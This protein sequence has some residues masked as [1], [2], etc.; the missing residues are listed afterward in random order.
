MI[1]TYNRLTYLEEALRS[2]LQQDPG[3]EEMQ[4]AVVDNCS[5]TVDTEAFIRKIAGDRVEF[6]RNP[7]NV[8][9]YLNCD[10][11]ITHARGHWVH[12]LHDDD[13]VLPGFYATLATAIQSHPEVSA[14]FCRHAFIDPQ[15]NRTFTMWLERE[16]A[17]V[18]DPGDWL[19]RLATCNRI[20]FPAIVVKRDAY[21]QAGGFVAESYGIA[22]DWEMWVRLAAAG[23]RFWYEPQI[24]ALYRQ[25]GAA[26]S[27]AH[28]QKGFQTADARR[29]IEVFSNYFPPDRRAQLAALGLD[30]YAFSSLGTAQQ[31]L[32]AGNLAFALNHLREALL[33]ST[34]PRVREALGGPIPQAF[35][36]YAR[37]LTPHLQQLQSNPGDAGAR[38]TLRQVRIQLADR[39]LTLPLPIMELLYNA[40]LGRIH[41]LLVS[42]GGLDLAQ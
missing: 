31:H 35:E 15:G 41:A 33:C 28:V 36:A 2:A 6:Y 4:I 3:P 22:S 7:Q 1:P 10:Q 25:H 38:N 9:T 11:C 5:T 17:G 27:A 42:P 13:A 32:H 26:G 21:Q 34:S 29:A 24:L 39:L 12:V 19:T 23:R 40:G 8:G 20:Q 18:F 14:A 30:H 16:T 37:L